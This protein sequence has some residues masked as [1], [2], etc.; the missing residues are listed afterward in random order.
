MNAA[1][2]LLILFTYCDARW[3]KPP[4]VTKYIAGGN[5]AMPNEYPYMGSLQF[6]NVG[7]HFCGAAVIGANWVLTAGHC[8]FE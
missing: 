3:L 5:K 6:Y 1:I 7:K 4:P 8:L 2:L